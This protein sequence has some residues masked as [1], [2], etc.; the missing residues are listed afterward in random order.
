MESVNKE[1][2]LKPRS[3]PSWSQA[4]TSCEQTVDSSYL[5]LKSSE[6]CLSGTLDSCYSPHYSTNPGTL[7]ADAIPD[8]FFTHVMHVVLG[9]PAR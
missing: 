6:N 8:A 4:L 7:V 5:R 2:E 1:P 9:N 3:H